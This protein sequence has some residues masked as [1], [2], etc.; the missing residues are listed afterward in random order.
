MSGISLDITSEQWN[1]DDK[2]WLKH[3]L[4]FDTARPCTLDPALFGATELINGAIASGTVVGKVTASGLFGPYDPDGADGRETAVG[5]LLN[6]ARLVRDAN[7]T[8]TNTGI[9]TAFIWQGI[10]DESKLP[11]LAGT[12]G[13]V[14]AAAKADLPHVRFE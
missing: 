3:Q 5:L 12:E 11:A 8:G 10:V 9:A 4:G 1:T 7:E 13:I 6:G 14:D 2:S